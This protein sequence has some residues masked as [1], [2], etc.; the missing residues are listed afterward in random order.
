MPWDVKAIGRGLALPDR[1]IQR[2]HEQRRTA[3]LA[4]LLAVAWS[5]A[6]VRLREDLL[7]LLPSISDLTLAKRVGVF[8]EGLRYEIDAV[9]GHVLILT[10][11]PWLE[12]ALHYG[13]Q[14]FPTVRPL[15]RLVD[16][17]T[18]SVA[19][20]GIVFTCRDRQARQE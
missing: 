4:P 5:R 1:Y 10:S 11:D 18:E 3:M 16:Y 8:T 2:A 17:L 15:H 7:K 9:D 12:R 14:A 19:L 20:S 6:V 13:T